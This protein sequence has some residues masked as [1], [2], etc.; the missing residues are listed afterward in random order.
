MDSIRALAAFVIALVAEA[1]LSPAPLVIS[2]EHPVAVVL[3]PG[4]GPLA[5]LGA[6]ALEGYIRLVT[7]N[8][9][10]IEQGDTIPNGPAIILRRQS[11][12][13]FRPDGYRIR[14]ESGTV[15]TVSASGDEGL[16]YGCY[17]LIRQMRQSGRR[18]EVPPITLD[19][20]PR[21]KER[22]LFVAEIEWHPT[23]GEK[24]AL[25]ELH[26]RFDWQ[27]WPLAKV[28][29]YIELVDAMGY[30]SLM[31]SDGQAFVRFGGGLTGRSEVT[32]KVQSMYQRARRQGLRTAFFLWTQEGLKDAGVSRNSPRIP[33]QFAD[34]QA[35]WEALLS[36]YGPL[37]DRWVLH[38]ADP[39]GCRT[40]DCTINTPQEA[41]NRFAELLRK[42]NPSSDVS[43]SL[44][45]LR[46]GA[47][48]G[49]QDERKSVIDAGILFPSIGIN[50]MRTFDA[51]LTA[52]IREQHRTAGVWGWY[53][54][55]LETSPSMHVHTR[56]L[57]NEFRQLDESV[58]TGLDWY[59]LEDNDH[60]LNL[61]SLYVGS[62]MLWDYEASAEA[63][64]G[65]FCRAT[66]GREGPKVQTA[67]QAIADIRCGP[68]Q[69]MIAS[70]L[71]PH[72]YICRL[73]RGTSSPP[74]DLDI[75]QKALTALESVRL[76]PD[77]VPQLPLVTD[78][79][80]LLGHIREHLLYVRNFAS[81]RRA[82]DE[83][84]RPA[85]EEYQFEQ[86]A[87]RMATL[88]AIRDVIP[89]S[90]GAQMEGFQYSLLRKFADAWK[91]RVFQDDLAL[92]K[93]VT[94]SSWNRTDPRYAPEHAV[95]GLLCD[96]REEGWA[97]DHGPAW[98]KIDLG[99]LDRV[100]A[101]RIYNRGYH[102]D[103]WDQNLSAT[104]A[105]AQV[106]FAAVDPVPERGTLDAAE[107]G[108]SLLG[109]FEQW[110]PTTDPA[111][112][113]EIRGPKPIEARFIK[114]L[115]YEAAGGQAPGCGE[116]EVR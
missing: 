62:Q 19:A 15:I 58:S 25:E 88:P 30:N 32:R 66:W 5:R 51:A 52:A 75:C 110:M 98:I 34:M 71:W 61:P 105:R 7:G 85:V 101:V 24:A 115:I 57:E 45:A 22:Q 35:N 43:F 106:F 38:W 21:I 80:E 16:K 68:G 56:V 111:A 3:W 112:Y 114:V 41:T 27:N 91:A 97:A 99:S 103:V 4:A 2:A 33:E 37:V 67:L 93:P 47:W 12:P 90:Y 65:E 42:K 107:L 76:D 108:Y 72:G 78:P 28:E 55:D 1:P 17:R 84:L 116:I 9:P 50:L 26:T 87:Q 104:P 79:R 8:A 64:L 96:F 44:W 53:L 48:P 10:R 13:Y 69:H 95:N 20:N 39:G 11:I 18:L 23:P 77:F 59:S 49:F 46:W 94:A 14:T 36:L 100:Q 54:N 86:T 89:G 83:A 113:Q 82:Y 40:R 29:R 63:A 31:L 60:I 102:R 81:I 73:G 109:G 74:R 92:R 6:Q 70:D